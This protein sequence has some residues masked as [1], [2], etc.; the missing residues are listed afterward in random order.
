MAERADHG[1]PACNGKA[2]SHARQSQRTS[3]ERKAF[4]AACETARQNLTDLAEMTKLA[5]EI[6]SDDG[7]LRTFSELEFSEPCDALPR[8]LKFCA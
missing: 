6:E 8:A 5:A 2:G 4:F 3:F 7:L 1:T